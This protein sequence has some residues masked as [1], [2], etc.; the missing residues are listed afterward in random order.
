YPGDYNLD[1]Q[2]DGADYVVVDSNLGTTTPG[3]SG[4]WTLGDGDFDGLITPADY[5]PIDSNFGSGVGNPLGGNP[6]VNAI[7]EPSAWVLGS[8]AAICFTWGRRRK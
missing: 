5:L 1:G 4:G 8:L 2:V 7:P 3:L 6:V